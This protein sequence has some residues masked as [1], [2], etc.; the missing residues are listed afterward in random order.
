MSDKDIKKPEE[1]TPP[2]SSEIINTEK[3][4]S[5]K[6]RSHKKNERPKAKTQSNSSLQLNST[7]LE[8]MD[9]EDLRNCIYISQKMCD[10]VYASNFRTPPDPTDE[11]ALAFLKE[12][13][14]PMDFQTL[15]NNLSNNV[16][17]TVAD[18]RKDIVLIFEN[19]LN[20]FQP[21]TMQYESALRLKNKFWKL[22]NIFTKSEEEI[23]MNKIEKICSEYISAEN[24]Q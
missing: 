4:T 9:E 8:N 5:S 21:K 1:K 20:H 11:D 14:K 13:E 6:S 16:Y 12:I 10:S 15:M 23:W 7:Q 22:N 17:K 19:V 3:A 2:N 18:W 24:E